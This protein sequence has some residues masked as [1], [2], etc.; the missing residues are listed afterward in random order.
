MNWKTFVTRVEQSITVDGGR[1]GIDGFRSTLVRAAVLDLQHYIPKF[2]EGHINTLDPSKDVRE[3]GSAG[4][5]ESPPGIIRELWFLDP[6]DTSDCTYRRHRFDF[7]AWK[8]RHD[9]F[10]GCVDSGFYK[11][12]IDVD[13]FKDVYVFPL[14]TD[15]QRI[16]IRWDGRKAE[17]QDLDP[18]PWGEDAV[19]CAAEYVK[20]R[21]AREVDHDLQLANSYS[22]S[23]RQLRS[24]LYIEKK[25]ESEL[26]RNHA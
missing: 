8:F 9:L 10:R 12:T 1:D 4:K 6:D 2:R 11:A 5:I 26:V 17:F 22:Q 23:H 3:E 18:L 19:L 14:P 13:S 20:A 24:Q 25:Q 21:I 7:I 16:E 15:D